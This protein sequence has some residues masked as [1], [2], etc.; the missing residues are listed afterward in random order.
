MWSSSQFLWKVFQLLFSHRFSIIYW[1]QHSYLNSH[2]K[3]WTLW[4]IF[5]REKYN[6]LF[7]L[8]DK[9]EIFLSIDSVCNREYKG[10]HKCWRFCQ[11]FS[12]YWEAHY[13]FHYCILTNLSLSRI[14]HRWA[15]HHQIKKYINTEFISVYIM[16]I[17]PRD[18]FC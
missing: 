2:L 14:S 5:H 17:S 9:M 7:F 12:H 18:I 13:C 1:W 11:T 15:K 6:G 10:R 8:Y 3:F 16:V 4:T